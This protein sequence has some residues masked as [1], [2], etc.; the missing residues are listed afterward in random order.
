VDRS[1]ERAA[2]IERTGE[3]RAELGKGREEEPEPG[4]FLAEFFVERGIT[5]SLGSTIRQQAR[6]GLI[7]LRKLDSHCSSLL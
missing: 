1:F 3:E 2:Q 4:L 5:V 7:E 6:L